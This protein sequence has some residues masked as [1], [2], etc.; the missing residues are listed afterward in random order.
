MYE[1]PKTPVNQIVTGQINGKD[2]NHLKQGK[3]Q[4]SIK[5][6][7]DP[8]AKPYFLVIVTN[9]KHGHYQRLDLYPHE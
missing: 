1:G 7:I 8:A 9:P 5:T 4:I 6:E 3:N 2:S